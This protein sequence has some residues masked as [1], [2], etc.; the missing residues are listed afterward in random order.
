MM[1]SDDGIVTD[2][3][4]RPVRDQRVSL[5][6]RCN[7]RCRYCMPREVFG[8]DHAFVERDEL[9]RF[10]G[11]SVLSAADVQWVLHSLP[12]GPASVQVIVDRDGTG[13]T[14][15]LAL[16]AR[17]PYGENTADV[18]EPPRGRKAALLLAPSPT[19]HPAKIQPHSQSL[20]HAF[21]QT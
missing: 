19:N 5:T 20:G 15:T 16:P 7:L 2:R 1:D 17:G 13:S 8:A 10:G 3:L 11:Q 18:C 4:G 21:G 14:H 9:L 12:P 6:D